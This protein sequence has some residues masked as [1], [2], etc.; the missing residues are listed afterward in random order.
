MTLSAEDDTSTSTEVERAGLWVELY[1]DPEKEGLLVCAMLSTSLL[2]SE[3]SELE[4]Y[5]VGRGAVGLPLSSLDGEDIIRFCM[6]KCP[7]I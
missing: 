3:L 2:W 5:W 4:T 1:F 7:S 6:S